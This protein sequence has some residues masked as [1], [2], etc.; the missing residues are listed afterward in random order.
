MRRG[1]RVGYAG[2]A[3][4]RAEGGGWRYRLEYPLSG[5]RRRAAFRKVAADT[6]LLLDLEDNYHGD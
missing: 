5:P 6:P 2:L 1:A 4:H 3:R